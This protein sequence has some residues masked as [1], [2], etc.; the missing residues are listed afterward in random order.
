M[1]IPRLLFKYRTIVVYLQMKKSWGDE[2]VEK[3]Y[4]H[5]KCLAL[6]LNQTTVA[7]A[8]VLNNYNKH[9]LKEIQ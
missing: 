9:L 2:L 1:L 3:S 4:S 6:T 7:F 5:L 8:Y